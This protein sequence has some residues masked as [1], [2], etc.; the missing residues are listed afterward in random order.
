MRL[1]VGPFWLTWHAQH[2]SYDS[3]HYFEDVA[4]RSPFAAWRHAHRF[5]A[6]GESTTLTDELEWRLPLHSLARPLFGRF[7][8]AR[9]EAMFRFRHRRTSEDLLRH[10]SH[11]GRPLRIAISGTS[12]LVGRNLA[13]FLQTGG[14]TVA[15]LVRP[16]RTAPTGTMAVAWDPEHPELGPISGFDAVVHLAGAPVADGR[17]TKRRRTLI[18]DSRVVGTRRLCEALAALPEPPGV[19]VSASAIGFYGTQD[20]PVTEA[21]SEGDG[22]LADVCV[23]WEAAADAARAAGIRVVH[24]RIGVVL[25]PGGGALAKMLPLW[26]L[27]LGGPMGAGDQ[28]VSWI[29]LDDLL[30]VLHRCVIDERLE[31]P[32][33][34]VAPQAASNREFAHELA[35]VVRRPAWLSV[36]AIA[37]RAVL[38]QL[39]EET[40]LSGSSV[41][42]ARLH[43][44]GFTWFH[45]ELAPALRFQLGRA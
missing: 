39:A 31:G 12:G 20:R 41:V 16:N 2:T 13:A 8:T 32:V 25:D 23:A 6:D 14:H 22:F 40:L 5:E 18:R 35:T 11:S 21:D 15:C 45:P 38:G 4:L 43:E 1:R 24:P 17:W 19:L 29:A 7:I 37:M 26:R 33:N 36:P 10:T 44:V 30:G 9:L 27:G 42:P 28:P 34:A 3:P